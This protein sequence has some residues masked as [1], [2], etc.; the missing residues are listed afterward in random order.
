MID[1]TPGEVPPGIDTTVAHAARVY[2]YLLG[3]KDHFEVDRQVGQRLSAAYGGLDVAMATV[4]ANRTFLGRAVRFLVNEAG[5]R[6]F[7]DLGT[8]LP[9]ADHVHEVA[10][11]EAPD[12]RIVYVDND[13]L[14][15]THAQTLLQ[16]TSEGATTFINGDLRD[17]ENI[18]LRAATV[19]DLDEP[20][21]VILSAILHLMPDEGDEPYA[22]VAKL[23]EA[24]PS[25]S[26]LVISHM[27]SDIDIH[28]MNDLVEETERI[29]S[30]VGY[31][32]ALRSHDEIA[33]FLE[34]LVIVPPGIVRVDEWRPGAA[35]D[36]PSPVYAV[37]ARKP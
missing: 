35:P 20:V 9:S 36:T 10:Q 3:G 37:V 15:L 31:T 16:S 5:V 18:L 29:Q 26:Y 33:R 1:A 6:Q 23:I 11:R 32:F 4:R 19:L 27:A 30:S 2:D 24:V 13:P 14:V 34:G 17:A 7:L 12:C 8:G 25:G 22:L 28:S 21:A